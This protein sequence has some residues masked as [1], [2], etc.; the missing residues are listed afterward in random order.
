MINPASLARSRLWCGDGGL[1]NG[2]WVVVGR[3]ELG[4]GVGKGREEAV[5]IVRE[6][7]DIGL[8]RTRGASSVFLAKHIR[9]LPP[10]KGF[11]SFSRPLPHS[12]NKMCIIKL[13]E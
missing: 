2:W 1:W 7:E 13:K 5:G 9:H 6:G 10:K 11:C 8:L 3:R 12:E 4:R